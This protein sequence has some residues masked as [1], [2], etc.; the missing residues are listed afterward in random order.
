CGHGCLYGSDLDKDDRCYFEVKRDLLNNRIKYSELF[1]DKAQPNPYSSMDLETL[2]HKE[3]PPQP[4]KLEQPTEDQIKEI[5]KSIGRMT[6]SDELN[7]GSCGYS[8]CREKAIAV[9]NGIAEP[10]MC[11]PYM[12]N[13]AQ[14]LSNII[15]ESSPNLIGLVDKDLFIIELNPAAEAFFKIEK[16]EAN[17]MPL[18]MYLN[19]EEF[20]HVRTFRKNVRNEKL[21]FEEYDNSTLLQ[22]IYWLDEN[23]MFLWLAVD[24]TKEEKAADKLQT[25][26]M[27]TVEMAQQVVAK[28]MTVAQEIAKLLGETTA[29]T[30]VTL[31]KLKDLILDEEE[32]E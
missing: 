9:F 26:R 12:K 32:N 25:L 17:G 6:R 14:S 15:C 24:I 10:S 1:S 31:T 29:E 22:T 27:E 4:F 13:R 21:K 5:L 8:T 30:K 20:E 3:Y 16:N 23:Q 2:L 19:E 7:C 28:Q 11:L 18:A